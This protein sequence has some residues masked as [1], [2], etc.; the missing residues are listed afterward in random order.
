LFENNKEGFARHTRYDEAALIS[1]NPEIFLD[2]QEGLFKGL[3][4]SF[5]A[6][7]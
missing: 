3:V 2:C 4:V 1:L 7:S 5:L 6:T